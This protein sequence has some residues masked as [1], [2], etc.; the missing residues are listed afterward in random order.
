MSKKRALDDHEKV[1]SKFIS[2]LNRDFNFSPVSWEKD[3]IPEIIFIAIVIE[4]LGE[5]I[6]TE[7]LIEIVKGVIIENTKVITGHSMLMISNYGLLTES[8]KQKTLDKWSK[9]HLLKEIQLLLSPFLKKYPT[10]PLSFIEDKTNPTKLSVENYKS[11]LNKL[12]DRLSRVS[13]MTQAAVVYNQFVTGK[14]HV[15]SS[16]S[17]AQFPKIEDY[18]N[19]E[20][21]RR[22]ASAIRNTIK[23]HHNAQM[24]NLESN[25]RKDFWD[26][27][28]KI[29]PWKI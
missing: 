24:F 26:Y 7:F 3:T 23:M 18:P 20:L 29:E 5:K 6:G 28:Y 4:N 19:T 15:T 9:L 27:S 10:C 13:T 8:D 1:G 14:L 2:P 21:S 25:W 16:S 11:I 22:I 12:Q 17:L